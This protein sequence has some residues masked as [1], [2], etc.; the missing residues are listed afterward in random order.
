VLVPICLGLAA[1]R[2]P[3][4]VLASSHYIPISNRRLPFW[5][6]FPRQTK[7]MSRSP[8][9]QT[10]PNIDVGKSI[11]RGDW[12]V[13]THKRPILNSTEIEAMTS[14]LGISPPEMIFGNNSVE[15]ANEKL[16]WSIS[17][18]ALDALELVD[19]SG[20]SMLKVSYSEAWQKM[21]ER[22]HEDIKEIVKPYDWTY[23]TNYQGTVYVANLHPCAVHLF[24][25]N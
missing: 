4:T 24:L 1:A 25:D 17:F 19:K 5:P 20:E 2:Y 8:P 6:S 14:T 15:V 10:A 12:K 9:L 16:N 11:T 13:T 21:R 7:K 18:N 3:T 22:V 23:T